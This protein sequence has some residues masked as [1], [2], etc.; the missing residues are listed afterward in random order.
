MDDVVGTC[1]G[2]LFPASFALALADVQYK[3]DELLDQQVPVFIHVWNCHLTTRQL[4]AHAAQMPLGAAPARGPGR[5]AGSTC[6]GSIKW[7]DGGVS[8]PD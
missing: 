1:S 8:T 3:T 7:F 6:N 2:E 4:L 5:R